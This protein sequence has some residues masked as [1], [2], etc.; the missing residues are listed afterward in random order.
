VRAE[1]FVRV[2]RG[3]REHHRRL[4]ILGAL[5]AK[6]TGL[7][8]EGMT[9]VGGSALEIYTQGDYV[10]G[11]ADIVAESEKALTTALQ[12]WEFRRDRMYWVHP[13]F[14]DLFVQFVGRY[15]SG[16]QSLTR[17]VDTPY[18]S[19]RLGSIE[20]I[21]VKRL[22]GA[23]HWDR[24]DMFAEAEVAVRRYGGEMDWSYVETQAKREGVLDL[25][26]RIRERASP[27]TR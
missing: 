27:P 18:G 19:V 5:L 14:K 17:I 4:L 23:R 21:V 25:V 11:D 7:G 12:A 1:E 9:I 6:E 15:N 26:Q 24:S 20:D 13:E 3:E 16:S 10:S 8:T 2:L 22:V